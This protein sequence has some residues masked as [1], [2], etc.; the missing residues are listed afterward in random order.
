MFFGS[1][2]FWQIRKRKQY[3]RNIIS[4]QI[5]LKNF[6]SYDLLQNPPPRVSIYYDTNRPR[7][8]GE[9]GILMVSILEADNK[10]QLI[11]K[12]DSIILIL[13]IIIASYFSGGATFLIIQFSLFC[14]L[15]FIPILKSARN[16]ALEHVLTFALILYRWR[17]E[18]PE[19]CAQWT[20]N[21][22]PIQPIYNV[23]KAVESQE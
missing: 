12:I 17:L 21:V 4:D 15:A 23:V 20:Q 11:I 18:Y 19:E 6:I 8:A 7:T 22:P 16:N 10:S 14:L 2:I 13:I 9:Y 1:G 5:F 3:L